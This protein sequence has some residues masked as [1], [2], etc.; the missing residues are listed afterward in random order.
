M[1]IL[2]PYIILLIISLLA[3]HSFAQT[4][5]IEAIEELQ[6]L[7]PIEQDEAVYNREHPKPKKWDKQNHAYLQEKITQKNGADA[8]WQKEKKKFKFKQKEKET[9]KIIEQPDDYSNAFSGEGWGEGLRVFL[10]VIGAIFV[11]GLIIY[12]VQGGSFRQGKKISVDISDA[13]LNWIEENLPEAD[14]LTPLESAILAKEYRKAIRLYFLLIVQRLTQS[15]E[16]N[17]QKEKTNRAYILETYNK[18]YHAPFKTCV[19]IYERVWYGERQVDE[20]DFLKIEPTF[21]QLSEQL[22][23]QILPMNEE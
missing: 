22:S 16:I 1:K 11:I 23:T 2:K 20:T 18:N 15:G 4:E 8:L 3:F 17:W 21:K 6:Y 7:D 10:L 14:V 9:T 19:R 12:L 5:E 13:R